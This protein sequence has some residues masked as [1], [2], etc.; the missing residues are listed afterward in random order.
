MKQLVVFTAVWLSVWQQTLAQN[1]GSCS[2]INLNSG[3]V[4]KLNYS[5]SKTANGNVFE[6]TYVVFDNNK[7]PYKIITLAN[8][9]GIQVIRIT[10][11]NKNG[12]PEEEYP[13]NY[14]QFSGLIL[15]ETGDSIVQLDKEY[16]YLY[17][18]SFDEPAKQYVNTHY[19]TQANYALYFSRVPDSVVSANKEYLKQAAM[20]RQMLEKQEVEKRAAEEKRQ[21]QE[22]YDRLTDSIA[23]E[24]VKRLIAQTTEKAALKPAAETA[25]AAPP[26]NSFAQLI[27]MQMDTFFK[28]LVDDTLRIDQIKNSINGELKKYKQDDYDVAGETRYAGDRKGMSWQGNGLLVVD[29]RKVYKGEFQKGQFVSGTVI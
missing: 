15:T 17:L 19:L 2:F 28:K 8:Q 27:I 1:M 25:P 10:I 5:V 21:Q 6:T 12:E 24:K 16:H 7:I 22:A 3:S 29:N 23:N 20:L 4:Q 14:N 11:R 13:V 18:F 26:D 9:T